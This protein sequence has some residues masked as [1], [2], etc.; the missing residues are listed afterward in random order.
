MDV[1]RICRRRA[2]T[3]DVRA[4]LAEAARL[5]RE[6]HV[7]FLVVCDDARLCG[8]LTDRDIVLE[9]VACGVSPDQVTVGDAMTADPVTLTEGTTLDEALECLRAA[10][11]RRAPVVDDGGRIAGVLSLDD[12]LDHLADQLGSV[13]GSLRHEQAIERI[14]RP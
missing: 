2:V 4:D 6:E 9:A 3:I 12:V 13:A 8:V 14:A 10:G 1:G 7:G 5:M 11:V